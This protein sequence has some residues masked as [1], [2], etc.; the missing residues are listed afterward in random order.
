MSVVTVSREYGTGGREF[1]KSLA[2]EMG[3]TYAD[4]IVAHELAKKMNMKEGYIEHFLDT[5]I[6]VGMSSSDD[7]TFSYD[8]RETQKNVNLQI[9]SHKLLKELAKDTDLVIVG[10]ASD[11]I[12]QEFDPF[13]IFVYANDTTR[14]ANIKSKKPEGKNLSDMDI[15]REMNMIDNERHQHHSLFS[16]LRWG[17]K[18][19][20]DLCIN[21]TNIDLQK[22]VPS[23]A[24]FIKVAMGID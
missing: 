10:R 7:S 18:E 6:P 24:L 13:R 14:I 19:A 3:F 23:I 16:R 8:V 4:K 22:S 12:L 21:S 2:E 11:I 20:Y 9:E 17:E 5:G 1:A 15:V